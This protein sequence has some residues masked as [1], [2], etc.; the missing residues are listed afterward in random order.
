[1]KKE[2]EGER[3]IDIEITWSSTTISFGQLDN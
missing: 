3:E 2:R 1:M